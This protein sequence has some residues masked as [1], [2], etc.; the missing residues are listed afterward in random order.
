MRTATA[1]LFAMVIACVLAMPSTA[2]SVWVQGGT[3]TISQ[4]SGGELSYRW[5]DVGGFLSIGYSQQLDVGA[6]VAYKY[7]SYQLGAGDHLQTFHLDTDNF[8]SG[9]YFYGRGLHVTRNGE[10]QRWT[11]FGGVTTIQTSPI[12]YQSFQQQDPTGAFFFQK[13]LNKKWSFHSTSIVQ[14]KVTSLHSFRYRP[15]TNLALSAAAG[16]GSNQ[17]YAA[18]GTDYTN[19]FVQFNASFTS[20]GDRFQRI[21]G[22]SITAPERIGPNLRL[23]VTPMRS[24]SATYEHGKYRGVNIDQP[25][26][27]RDAT[28]D[29]LSASSSIKGVQLSGLLTASSSGSLWTHTQSFT[30]SRNLLNGSLGFAGTVMRQNTQ[31]SDLRTF[32]F[33]ADQ[34]VTTRFRLHEY[35]SRTGRT[36][37][38]TGGG[39]FVS[40]LAT[41]GVD[42]QMI[43]TPLAGTGKDVVQA[44]TV[45]FN[46]HIIDSIRLHGDSYIDPTGRV[47]Y[48]G[49]LDGIHFSR[50]S[51]QDEPQS[52]TATVNFGK[53]VV[54]G[55]VQ[56]EKGAPVWGIAVQVDGKLAYTD[57]SGRF[58]IR[59]RRGETSPVAVLVEQS[60]SPLSY[61]VVQAPVSARAETEDL[62]PTHI[63]IVRRSFTPPHVPPET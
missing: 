56:D 2:Q 20:A 55:I 39:Q 46:I 5:R 9:R 63:F 24:L 31:S 6:Y 50:A 7:R 51:D 14:G 36:N 42:H 62:A 23:R 35:Y 13:E 37:T 1:V 58:F 8:E 10:N 48:T 21:G 3:S 12:L 19:K 30:A 15:L 61:E 59:F 53:F 54:K 32:L 29:S 57:N 33:S 41:I 18:L 38:I 34:K 26:A 16:V 49:W 52:P 45:N 17:H 11:A 47:R 44:W 60:L 25:S 22:V 43:Y 28:L 40:N 4:A 27:A